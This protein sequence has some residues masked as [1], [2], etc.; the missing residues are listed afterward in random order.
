MSDCMEDE[1]DMDVA[2]DFSEDSHVLEVEEDEEA[3]CSISDW[4]QVA[5]VPEMSYTGVKYLVIKVTKKLGLMS[6][7][8]TIPTFEVQERDSSIFCFGLSMVTEI[9]HFVGRYAAVQFSTV[10][11]G[12][13]TTHSLFWVPTCDFLIP[14]DHREE[15]NRAEEHCPAQSIFA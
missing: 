12:Q 15:A 6:L 14:S 2:S 4:A 9:S 7:V 5:H 3:H 13:D 1:A 10:D 11:A 8:Y